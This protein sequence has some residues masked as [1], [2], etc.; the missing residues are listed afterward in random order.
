MFRVEETPPKPSCKSR[1][2]IF[3]TNILGVHGQ[4]MGVLRKC[5]GCVGCVGRAKGSVKGVSG[6]AGRAKV[7]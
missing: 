1:K 3:L 4:C 7:W 5:V 6:R 2:Q